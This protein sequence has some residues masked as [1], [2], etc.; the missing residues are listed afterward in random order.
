MV[1]LSYAGRRRI[2]PASGAKSAARDPTVELDLAGKDLTDDGLS[3]FIDDLIECMSY[4]DSEYP[5][6]VVRLTELCLKG[7]KLSVISMMRLS[8]IIFLGSTTLVKVDISNNGVCIVSD[9]ERQAWGAFLRSFQNC[10]VLKKVDFSGNRLG[11]AGF[12]VLERIYLKSEVDFVD[13]SV[14]PAGVSEY[15]AEKVG[16]PTELQIFG[17]KRGLRSVPYLVFSRTCTTPLCAFHLWSIITVH[18]HPDSLLNYLPAGK[19]MAPVELEGKNIGVV[20]APNDDL[21]PL[22]KGFLDLGN[23][24]FQRIGSNT[25]IREIDIE[26]DDSSGDDNRRTTARE[27]LRMKQ[28]EME[29][30]QKRVLLSALES[31]SLHSVKLWSV[32]FKLLVTA[33][34]VLLD[35]KN[36]PQGISQWSYDED[37]ASPSRVQT[38]SRS[39]LPSRIW[40][41]NIDEEFPSLQRAAKTSPSKDLANQA[42]QPSYASCFRDRTTPQIQATNRSCYRFGLPIYIWRDIL[43]MAVD[44]GGIL[45]K[46][47]QA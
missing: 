13:S 46:E 11:S 26:E 10:C 25:T 28:I 35:E 7:N 8:E 43:A 6:G 37:T 32:A 17:R 12:D 27:L 5:Q 36:R 1:K 40:S 22:S 30:V 33:R 16:C 47:Q 41:L 15:S 19:S 34:A 39:S 4:R 14:V 44:D 20:Y 42:Q 23:E 2:P 18:D 45:C 31:H 21:T 9:F 3:V 29:R 38:T 24:T